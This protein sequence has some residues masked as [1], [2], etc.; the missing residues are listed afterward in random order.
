MH[1]ALARQMASLNRCMTARENGGSRQVRSSA[2][3]VTPIRCRHG[4]IERRRRR[5][6][7]Y[8]CIYAVQIP[9]GVRRH[10]QTPFIAETGQILFDLDETLSRDVVEFVA[11][12]EGAV[13]PEACAY[14]KALKARSSTSQCAPRMD[15]RCRDRS[16]MD[17]RGQWGSAAHSRACLGEALSQEYDVCGCMAP[18]LLPSM[19]ARCMLSKRTR[20]AT[21]RRQ[22]VPVI[23]TV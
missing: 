8:A 20:C 15:A 4:Q 10:P 2:P 13:E 14:C 22:A 6:C 3:C 9:R 19:V 7:M 11:R 1:R 17:V 21:T 23:R 5:P 12:R 16:A 18:C